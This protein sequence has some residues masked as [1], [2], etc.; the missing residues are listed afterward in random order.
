MPI[1]KFSTQKCSCPKEKQGQK[2]K[3]K[4]KKKE[5]EEAETEERPSRDCPTRASR[6]LGGLQLGRFREQL[7]NADVDAWSQPSD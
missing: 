2:K 6:I 7:T 3:K 4:R 1:S 5:K